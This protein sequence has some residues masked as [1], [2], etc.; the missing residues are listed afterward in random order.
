MNTIQLHKLKA[1]RMLI[2]SKDRKTIDYAEEIV[3]FKF[4]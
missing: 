2:F 3:Y 1:F 4:S